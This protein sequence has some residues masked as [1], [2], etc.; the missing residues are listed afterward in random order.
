MQTDIFKQKLEEEKKQLEVQLNDLGIQDPETG[1]WGA[2]MDQANSVDLTDKNDTADRDED[3]AV[4]A[5]T[6]GPLEERWKDI[7][8][9]LDKLIELQE[10]AEKGLGWIPF[11]LQ[12]YLSSRPDVSLE[13]ELDGVE[14][15]TSRAGDDPNFADP[16]G[17]ILRKLLWFR[18]I[19]PQGQRLV[20]H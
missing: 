14:Y 6:L 7:V 8:A 3:F 9:A 2:K 11:E 17:P 15:R 1:D 18:P 20:R 5:N 19:Y 4:T 12:H 13:Y 10:A 16:P